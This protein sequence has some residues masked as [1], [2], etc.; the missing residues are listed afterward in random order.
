MAKKICEKYSDVVAVVSRFAFC[1]TIDDVG[2]MLSK[3]IHPIYCLKEGCIEKYTIPN[4]DRTSL[5]RNYNKRVDG[6][7]KAEE[8]TEIPDE[9]ERLFEM[10]F[11][12]LGIG[13]KKYV[14]VED[15]VRVRD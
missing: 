6:P 8:L 10:V 12:T 2:R 5:S 11:G 4:F 9:I 13:P 7:R 14:F 3:E 15:Q 1:E